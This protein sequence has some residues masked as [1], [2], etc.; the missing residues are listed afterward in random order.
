MYRVG[1]EEIEAIAAVIRSKKLFRYNDTSQCATFEKRW[2]KY[3]NVKFAHMSASGT[4]ALTAGLSALGIGP[5]DEVIVPAHTYMASGAAVLAVGAIP[6][7]VDIDDSITLSPDAFEDA[8][9]P[10]TRGVIPV[11]MWG[12]VCDMD[13]IMK[14]AR[15]KKVFVIEDACQA[16]GGAYEGKKCGSIGH[17]GAFSFNYFKNMT[18]GEGGA[19]VSNDEK[20]SQ[21]ARCMIDCCG[22][23]WTGRNNDLVPFIANGSRAS[24]LEGAMLNV[25]LDRL[26]DMINQMRKQK[27][28]M[29]RETAKIGLTPV[30]ANSLNYECGAFTMYTLPTVEKAQ[31]FAQLA[32]GGIC[33]KTGRHTYTEWDQ[34]F[35]HEGGPH[36]AMNPFKMPQN[37]KCRKN[38]TKEM[39][40]KSLDILN[41]T[42]M[43][44]NHPDRSAADT[45]K[46]I[47]KIKA[48]AKEVL[49]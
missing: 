3:L 31:K 34:F 39:C 44:G 6:V 18:C 9:G 41:R 36:P 2:A 7:I 33:G 35:T 46:Q 1:E 11:H 22:F 20:V 32:G 25:Q 38:Y 45:K 37:K 12:Q 24:E 13:R 5:G 28:Q 10:R 47:E 30:R 40:A 16:V 15:K 19:V 23:Y 14:I 8:I 4:N 27:K 29:L 21:R 26:P 49:S 48:A 42:S 17:V 43:I